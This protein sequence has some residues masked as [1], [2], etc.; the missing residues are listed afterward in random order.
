MKLRGQVVKFT[1]NIMGTNWVHI[2]DGS[3]GDLT[4]TTSDVVAV[5][6][7]VM[8]EGTLTLDKDFGAGYRYD[9]IIEG[10]KLTKE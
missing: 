6:D 1:P 2:Q 4:V 9:A 3:Q 5:G 7:I 8:V 10:A